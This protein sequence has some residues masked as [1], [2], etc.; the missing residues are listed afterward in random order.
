MEVGKWREG[1]G[2]KAGG[3]GRIEVGDW[4]VVGEGK[5]RGGGI[6]DDSKCIFSS[7]SNLH[8]SLSN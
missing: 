7:E 1:K 6:L 8:L 3:S 5:G 4:K 2:W